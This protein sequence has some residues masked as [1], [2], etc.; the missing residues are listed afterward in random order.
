MPEPIDAYSTAYDALAGTPVEGDREIREQVARQIVDT[1][2]HVRSESGLGALRKLA[3]TV[4]F[5][6]VLVTSERFGNPNIAL[7]TGRLALHKAYEATAAVIVAAY[8]RKPKE[9]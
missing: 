7:L 9:S 1:L 2:M 6:N 5:N 3:G 8:S 4:Q